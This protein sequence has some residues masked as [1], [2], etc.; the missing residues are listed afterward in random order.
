MVRE[1]LALAPR[2]VELAARDGTTTVLEPESEPVFWTTP[3]LYL[4][5]GTERRPVTSE[6]LQA[7]ARLSDRLEAV[8]GV[9]GVAMADVPPL[10]R[11]FVGLRVI[12]EGTRKHARVLCFS[13]RGMDAL[14]RMKPVFPGPWFSIGFTAHGPLRWTN[15]ALEVFARSAGHGI[16]VTVNGEPMAGASAPVTLAG[17]FAVGNAEILAGIVVNQLL[18]PG[19][20]VIYNLGLGHVFDMRTR[21]RRHR[22]PRE[23]ALRPGLGRPR[24]L[25][26][27]ALLLLGLHRVGVRG[28][29]GRPRDDVRA[30]HP[31][32]GGREPRLG[33]RPARVGDDALARAAVIDDEMVAYVRRHRRGFAVD[34]ETLALDLVRSV[35]IAGSYLDTD[36]TREHH[37][38]E[39]FSPRLLNRRARAACPGPL[40]E[41]AAA[42]ARELLASEAE[43]TLAEHERAALIAVESAF[44]AE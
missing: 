21:H 17:A 20:P 6:D 18:E 1:Y 7:I 23:R 32:A 3:V 33:S 25:L 38:R 30:R 5:T 22:R 2:R 37:R 44:A 14:V 4:W 27:P 12:A 40:P 16:P 35:G 11:D 39:L 10:H 13:P 15:L 41:V 42:R 31:R 28:R 26:R 43:P 9:M 29:A 34:D 8:Q 19:R 24:P 36:H